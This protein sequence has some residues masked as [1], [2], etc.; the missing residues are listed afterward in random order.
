MDDSE[1]SRIEVT[2]GVDIPK[3]HLDAAKKTLEN[4][5]PGTVE[6]AAAWDEVKALHTYFIGRLEGECNAYMNIAKEK[7][8]NVFGM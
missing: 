1:L 8:R 2:F 3:E 7:A 6:Y 4:A 5:R